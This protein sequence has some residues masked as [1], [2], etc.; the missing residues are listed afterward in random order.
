MQEI[1]HINKNFNIDGLLVGS[2]FHYNLLAEKKKN[3]KEFD[4][5]IGNSDFL[6]DKNFFNKI[7][8]KIDKEIQFNKERK[9]IL[10]KNEKKLKFSILNLNNGNIFSIINFLK[11]NKLEIQLSKNQNDLMKSDVLIIS[12]DGNCNHCINEINNEKLG[13]LIRF[14]FEKKVLIGICS[15]MQILFEKTYE[16]GIQNGLSLF[17]GE[18][19]KIADTPIK[20][21][22]LGWRK[23]YNNKKDV[24]G[25]DNYK[26]YF[27]HSFTVKNFDNNECLYLSDYKKNKIPCI[28]KKNNSYAF[29]FHPEKSGINGLSLLKK[30]IEDI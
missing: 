20:L 6:N 11:K 30:I 7:N 10:I 24:L 8:E 27:M 1:E 13:D 17:R 25:I 18:I 28:F 23:I 12:G 26:F 3:I 19:K 5:E 14:F 2:L 16:D 21:P 22:N 4:N 29:Q 9:N 15:G